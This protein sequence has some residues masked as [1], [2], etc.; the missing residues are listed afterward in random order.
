MVS[1]WTPVTPSNGTVAGSVRSPATTS[2]SG[3]RALSAGLRV[4]A[5]TR[6]PAASSADTT[7]LPAFPVAPVTRYVMVTTLEARQMSR[8]SPLVDQ[9]L[10]AVQDPGQPELDVRA[11]RVVG[12]HALG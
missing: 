10:D 11:V 3:G 9:P 6:S 8:S 2:T 7:C 12:V 4:S 5:R 1:R